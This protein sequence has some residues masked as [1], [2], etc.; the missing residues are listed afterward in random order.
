MTKD[1]RDSCKSTQINNIIS[2]TWV[3]SIYLGIYFRTPVLLHG[4]CSWA[5]YVCTGPIC[6]LTCPPNVCFC[7]YI[8]KQYIK[9]SYYFQIA[10]QDSCLINTLYQDCSSHIIG[11]HGNKFCQLFI[12]L[13]IIRGAVWKTV[14]LPLAILPNYSLLGN[15]QV[16]ICS[17]NRCRSERQY[18]S[19]NMY[20][21]SLCFVLLWL[22]DQSGLDSRRPPTWTMYGCFTGTGTMGWLLRG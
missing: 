6:Y 8:C 22:Y 13:L 10:S 2:N 7:W 15:H 14:H 4:Y 21:G 11:D 9:N 16:A 20:T 5:N 18:T 19:W 1:N 12:V 17:G 3:N